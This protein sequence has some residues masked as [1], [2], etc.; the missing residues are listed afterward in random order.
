MTEKAHKTVEK[1][2]GNIV[3]IIGALVLFGIL[4]LLVV[5]PIYLLISY[6]MSVYK[7]EQIIK[8]LKGNFSDFWLNRDE[9]REFLFQ[10]V[11]YK[12]AVYAINYVKQNADT[13]RLSDIVSK[14][15]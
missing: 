3:S 15:A 1:E 14:R 13:Y 2:A 11:Q 4:I 9:K 12:N 7:N 5:V 6:L 10:S 8:K